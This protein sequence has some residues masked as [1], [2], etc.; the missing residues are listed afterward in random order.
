[1][2]KPMPN[3]LPNICAL[4]LAGGLGSRMNYQDKGLLPISDLSFVE[5]IAQ[6]LEPQVTSIYVSTNKN[7]KAYQALGFNCIDDFPFPSE[8]PLCA[9]ASGLE[10][11]KCEYLM[12]V[13]CDCPNIPN[14]LVKKLY[15]QIRKENASIASISLNG[16]IEPLFSLISTHLYDNLKEN[17]NKGVRK[18]HLWIQ[19]EKHVLVES[20][21]SHQFL[22]INTNEDFLTFITT[23][24]D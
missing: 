4:I 21:N 12:I 14:D 16:K 6:K 22:N 5:H 8:G 24:K 7:F 20:I 9:I 2:I 11:I 3:E 23:L 18:T 1:M 19:S 15:E 17:I 13:P 10:K